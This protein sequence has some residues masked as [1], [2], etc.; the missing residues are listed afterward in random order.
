M[1]SPKWNDMGF[2]AGRCVVVL[3]QRDGL[4]HCFLLDLYLHLQG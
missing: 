4:L 2:A 3:E 1:F